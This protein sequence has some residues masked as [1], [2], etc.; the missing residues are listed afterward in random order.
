MTRRFC[1]R[2]ERCRASEAKTPTLRL[3]GPAREAA[4]TGSEHYAASSVK[5]LL[6]QAVARYPA[7][8]SEILAT[9]RIWVN[10]DDVDVDHSLVDHDEV[11]VIPP[12]SGG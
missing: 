8:F 7:Q 2:I 12:I 6:E 4:G 9:S 5:E 11:A 3:F 1:S 10:G